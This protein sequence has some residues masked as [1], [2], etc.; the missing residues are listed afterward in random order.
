MDMIW[1][2]VYKDML[3]NTKI[4]LHAADLVVKGTQEMLFHQ[5]TDMAFTRQVS[6]L[7]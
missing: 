6:I 1:F 3:K 7:S 5:P 2:K 4:L